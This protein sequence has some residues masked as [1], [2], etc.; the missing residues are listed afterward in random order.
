MEEEHDRLYGRYG[1][2]REWVRRCDREREQ[3]QRK[4]EGWEQ[5]WEHQFEEWRRVR[6][7]RQE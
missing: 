6:D 2:G 1:K 3:L 5:E 4:Y 7:K